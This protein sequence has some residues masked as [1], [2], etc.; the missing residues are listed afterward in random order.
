MALSFGWAMPSLTA[1]AIGEPSTGSAEVID[2]PHGTLLIPLVAAW[3][4]T[5]Y[6]AEPTERWVIALA[7][8]CQ[9][10]YGHESELL[11]K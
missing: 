11:Q 3:E 9:N 6:A 8:Y 4:P 7:A 2:G 5:H 1:M 10:L